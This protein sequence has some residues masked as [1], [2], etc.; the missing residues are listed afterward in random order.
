V[1]ALRCARHER[2]AAGLGEPSAAS[3]I[4]VVGAAKRRRAQCRGERRAAE[5]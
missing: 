2:T 4:A 1:S 5:R 3:R